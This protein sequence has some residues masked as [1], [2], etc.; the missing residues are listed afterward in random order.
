MEEHGCYVLLSGITHIVSSKKASKKEL[1]VHGFLPESENFD[2]GKK[3]LYHA[4]G[5]LKRSRMVQV[6][7]S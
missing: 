4:K 1:D 7:A 3:K 6:S 2:L 5:H